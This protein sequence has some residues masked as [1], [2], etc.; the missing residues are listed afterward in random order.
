MDW[1]PSC[2]ARL[3]AFLFGW[4]ARSHP[5]GGLHC[6]SLPPALQ[7]IF[8]GFGRN[9]FAT[10]GNTDRASCTGPVNDGR[11]TRDETGQGAPL[12]WCKV[13]LVNDL[14]GTA[15]I[16]VN[17]KYLNP[18]TTPPEVEIAEDPKPGAHD[19]EIKK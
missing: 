3:P 17:S 5:R 10:R 2:R 15:E 6:N 12:G 16:K 13:T 9:S 14:P 4:W 8:G 18:E 11:Y 19:L 7:S 1:K